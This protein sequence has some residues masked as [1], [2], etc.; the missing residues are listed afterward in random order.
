MSLLLY[1]C[2]F[3]M[4]LFGVLTASTVSF[5]TAPYGRYST[6]ARGKLIPA[7]I[8]WFTFETFNLITSLL[9]L[10]LSKTQSSI[11]L[12]NYVLFGFFITHYFHR[13]IIYPLLRMPNSASPMP[14][15]IL[16]SGILFCAYNGTMQSYALLVVYEYPEHWIID[17]RFI[18]G[19]TLGITGAFINITSDSTLLRLRKRGT[20]AIPTGGL[21]N[22]VSCANYFGEIVE[23]TGFAIAAWS[24]PALAFSLY[25]MANLIP[26][27]ISHHR[28]YRQRFGRQYPSNRK[29]VIPFIL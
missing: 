29:A 17:A 10:L 25:T 2:A 26:R 7:R 4:I 14:I 22:V 16:L 18:I 3:G 28:S 5:I 1:Q 12:P 27:S 19:L 9:V 21:F 6:T 11:T 13:A 20:Y 24:L 23:W 15:S 8:A